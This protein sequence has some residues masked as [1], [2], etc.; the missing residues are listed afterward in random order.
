MC[1]HQDP[2]SREFRSFRKP[3]DAVQLKKMSGCSPNCGEAD[4]L[5]P[6]HTEVLSP[7][8]DTR[9]VKRRQFTCCGV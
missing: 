8:M 4:N 6:F 2:H 5:N 7:S 3:I 9:M 1:V